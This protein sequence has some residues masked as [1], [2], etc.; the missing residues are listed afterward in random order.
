MRENPPDDEVASWLKTLG[1]ESLCQWD[2]LVFLHR[3]QTSLFGADH[4]AC[5]LGYAT[6]PVVTALDVLGALELVKRSRVSQ[7]ARLYQL[8]AP[9]APPRGK[10][11]EQLFALAGDR[12]GRLRLSKQLQRNDRSPQAGPEATRCFPEEAQQVVR[13]KKQ[14]SLHR[15]K[16]RGTCRKAI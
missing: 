3:H 10:A 6:E 14:R 7:G 4:L 1:I 13:A 8:T 15:E 12:A 16:G 5:L 11:F 2:V 9:S